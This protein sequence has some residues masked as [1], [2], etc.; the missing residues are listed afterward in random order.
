MIS[1]DCMFCKI[2]AGE[3]PCHK[4]Y[5]NESVLAFLDIGPLSEGHILVIPKSHYEKVD[6]VV[7]D[8]LKDVILAVKK[9]TVALVDAL[10]CEGYN[11]LCNNGKVAGQVVKH[12]HFHVI[13]RNS[14][15]QVFTEWKAGSYPE[16]RA[17]TLANKICQK[18]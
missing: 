2:V 7:S 9:I 3:M 17:E 4:V 8:D 14:G 11:I 15:D 6:Q 16:G 13:P 18:L 5:E 1:Q 10:E 12:V